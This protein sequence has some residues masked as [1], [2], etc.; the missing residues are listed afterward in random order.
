VRTAGWRTFKTHGTAF[1]K[2]C[3]LDADR[4][5]Q[6]P[7]ASRACHSDS[8][9]FGTST[10]QLLGLRDWLVAHGV[11]LVGMEATGVYWKPVVRHE[12]P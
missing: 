7:A 3:R 2:G 11:T 1:P 5:G 12:A 10:P 6:I 8:A 9:T 4:R